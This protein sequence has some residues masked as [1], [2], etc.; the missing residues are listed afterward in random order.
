[1]PDRPFSSPFFRPTEPD[2]PAPSADAP[3]GGI[4]DAVYE[5]LDTAAR[6]APTAPPVWQA[7]PLAEAEPLAP[8]VQVDDPFAPE[9]AGFEPAAFGDGA[10]AAL[11]ALGEAPYGPGFRI[12]FDAPPTTALAP[13][14]R[15]EAV[16]PAPEPASGGGAPPVPPRVEARR[17]FLDKGEALFRHRRLALGL[18]LAGLLA[19]L[20]FG[21]FG[22]KKYE[23]YSLLLISTQQ[24]AGAQTPLVGD[25]VDVPG[26]EARK[27]LNQA[28]ILQ[29]APAIA[30]RTAARLLE[31]PGANALTFVEKLGDAPTVEALADYIQHKVITVRPADREVDAIRVTATSGDAEE[32]A[33]IA[34]V[35]TEEYAAMTRE[36]SRERITAVRTFLDEQVAR[37]RGEL[38]EIER[39]IAD[40]MTRSGAVGLDAQT[41]GAISQIATLQASL[42]RARIDVRMREATLRS[43]EREMAGL[44]NRMATRAASTSESEIRQLDSQITELERVVEQIYLRN[45]QYR[46]NAE[47]HP[48]LRALEGRLASL[49]EQKRRLAGDFAGDVAEAGGVNPSSTGAN[50]EGYVADL[51]RQIAAERAALD[52]ARA[53]SS[54]LGARLAEASGVLVTIPEQSRELAQLQRNRAATEQLVLFLTQKQQEAQVAEE[55]EF[56]LAQ[57]IRAP[58][59]PRKPSSPNLPMSLALGGMLGLLLGLA[60]AAFR[61]RTDA[62]IHTPRDL[63]AHGFVVVGTVPDLGKTPQGAPVDVEG[64]MVSPGLVALTRPF[65]PDAEAFRHLHAALQGT[66]APQVLVVTSPEVGCGKSLVAANLAVAAAQAGRRTLLVDGDLRRPSVHDFLGLGAS[67]AL[68]EGLASENLVYWSTAVPNLFALTAKEAADTPDDL[69]GPDRAGLLLSSLRSLFDLVVIDAPPGLVAADA[70]VL[71]PYCDAALLVAGADKTHADALTQVATEL[72]GAG[73][74]QIGAVLNR[75]DP[76]RHVGFS[77]TLGYRYQTKYAH[78]STA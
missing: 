62:R 17:A 68:G 66:S 76:K 32:A 52:G 25:F 67:P 64:R 2:A 77:R 70:A 48:D 36:T 59:V 4:Y 60:A 71:A 38:D 39:Q 24:P 56:G 41:Q 5:D 61:F 47:A 16:V 57:T 9:P 30:E 1:M 40:Y 26:L 35:Y 19:G 43:L 44:G 28:L 13:I 55:T 7:V 50:G 31:S 11:P 45:P 14:R 58:Q 37:R 53:E 34:T 49:R 23:A 21:L 20:L 27:V 42:D 46:G 63:E 3:S 73:L 33:R 65:S 29:Q 12:G 78:P 51:R 72:A 74:G 6:P 18:L 10:P 69:W 54:A 22:K 75:F 15:E 8:A